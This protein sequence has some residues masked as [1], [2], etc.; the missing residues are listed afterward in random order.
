[1]FVDVSRFALHSRNGA[2]K[3]LFF[4]FRANE[5]N[6]QNLLCHHRRASSSHFVLNR[7]MEAE[8][9]HDVAHKLW[10]NIG[11]P[12]ELNPAATQ[13]VSRYLG[14]PGTAEGLSSM[15]DIT[16]LLLKQCAATHTHDTQLLDDL[17]AHQA[18][19]Q[20]RATSS[21]DGVTGVGVGE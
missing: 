15:D 18:K 11:I 3:V 5:K 12:E 16:S 8:I 7:K 13:H 9:T 21:G 4:N 10:F 14:L 19:I 17:L 20:V 6:I 2:V 1:V